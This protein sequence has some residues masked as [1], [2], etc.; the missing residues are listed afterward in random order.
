MTERFSS[1]T[2]SLEKPLLPKELFALQVQFAS[3]VARTHNI[4]L[5]E[6]LLK[7]TSAHARLFH[8]PTKGV[9]EGWN[10]FIAELPDTPEGITESIYD[11][12]VSKE[13]DVET[14]TGMETFGC[15][16][17][18]YKEARNT[19]MLHFGN[20]DPEGNLGKD[21]MEIRQED[22][23]HLTE[24]IAG[25]QREEACVQMN[26]WLLSIDAFN[27][28]LP[29]KF[30]ESIHDVDQDSAY[31]NGLWGQFLDKYGGIKYELAE[32]LLDNLKDGELS[33]ADCFPCK[34]KT[35]R[36]PQEVFFD[37]Y[38]VN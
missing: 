7:Y 22:L 4:P 37:K 20:H 34:L 15:F 35:A 6:A 17:Y 21:R 19:F 2:E 24:S 25:Q 10:G 18:Q 11:A 29:E 13:K 23:R 1:K 26:S 16:S 14:A 3:E 31:D 9:A 33:V 27:R 5:A 38:I 30:V 32:Q 36:V 28:L 12:Y 8:H